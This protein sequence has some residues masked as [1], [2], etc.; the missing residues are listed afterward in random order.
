MCVCVCVCVCARACI[1]VCMHAY[2][3]ACVV[4]LHVWRLCMHAA[5][6]SGLLPSLL[7]EIPE[8]MPCESYCSLSPFGICSVHVCM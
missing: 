4:C 5:H 3:H 2:T 7:Q 1:C 6:Q 8:Q